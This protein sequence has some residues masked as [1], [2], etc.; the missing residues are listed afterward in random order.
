MEK[1]T[2]IIKAIDLMNYSR[3]WVWHKLLLALQNYVLEHHQ[4]F[5]TTDDAETILFS[6]DHDDAG[7]LT[8]GSNNVL[9]QYFPRLIEDFVKAVETH[10]EAEEIYSKYQ[11]KDHE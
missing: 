5:I 4:A 9:T 3:P 1:T 10:L 8:D 2:D 11:Q 7:S 6:T